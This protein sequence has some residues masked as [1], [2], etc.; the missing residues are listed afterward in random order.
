MFLTSSNKSGNHASI[1]HGQDIM[2]IAGEAS[3]DMHG[4]NLVRAMRSLNPQLRFS[5]IGGQ[6]LREAGVKVTIDNREL[7]VVGISEVA[8]KLGVLYGAIKRIRQDLKTI[9]PSLLILIDFPDFNL[10]VARSAKKLA[11]PVMY[12]ISPQVWAWRRGRGRKIK[13]LVDHMVVVFPFEA[14]FYEKLGVPVTFAG[15]PLL[16]CNIQ[17][18][19]GSSRSKKGEKQKAVGHEGLVIG[20]LPGSRNQEVARLLPGMVEAADIISGQF[21]AARFV[22]PVA[23]SV[24][25]AL[26]QSILKSP[27]TKI[28]TVPQSEVHNVF[29]QASLVIIASGTATL[30]AAIA[31]TPMIVVYKVSA[32]SYLL[33]RWLVHV[34]HICLA[35]LI[36]SKRI[37]PE[38]IQDD[39]TPE[40]M[41]KE[42]I[43]MLQDKAVLERIT[44]DLG[45][46]SECLGAPGA[47]R[48]A[49][50][51]ALRLA[52]AT[53]APRLENA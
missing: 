53:K 24:D 40:K 34:E 8:S 22:L 46:V 52:S 23:S 14:A 18:P 41:A 26:V 17:E 27:K 36:A 7:A 12:Y 38:L 2:I 25:A 47:S 4:A 44:H 16:D 10:I 39:A 3:G 13:K 32:L 49:A 35:N 51:V 9:R 45:K 6:A 28:I 19:F 37:V 50:E 20:L 43:S 30:E 31:G 5:G 33:A 48:R 11:I 1:C 15:H 21:P 29:A 42:A